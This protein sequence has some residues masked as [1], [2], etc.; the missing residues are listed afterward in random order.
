MKRLVRVAEHHPHLATGY[1]LSTAKV[2]CPLPKVPCGWWRGC[3][4]WV[5]KESV[6]GCQRKGRLNLERLLLASNAD[7]QQGGSTRAV[8]AV[9]AGV[10]LANLTVPCA[11]V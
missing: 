11:S 9:E 5:A 1:A 4:C 3:A 10:P 7:H 6:A 8:K 2:H